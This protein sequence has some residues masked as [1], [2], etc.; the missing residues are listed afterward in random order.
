MLRAIISRVF[1]NDKRAEFQER[2]RMR[3][4]LRTLTPQER[5]DLHEHLADEGWG[6]DEDGDGKVGDGTPQLALLNLVEINFP[7]RDVDFG[8][9]LRQEIQAVQVQLDEPMTPNVVD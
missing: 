7:E 2:A 1:G 8:R 4:F 3:T 9:R 6:Y 5:R